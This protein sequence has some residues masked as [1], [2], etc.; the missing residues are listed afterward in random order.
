[1]IRSTF[2]ASKLDASR[3]DS[4]GTACCM[5]SCGWCVTFGHN[6]PIHGLSYQVS[7]LPA[8]CC[9]VWKLKKKKALGFPE[10]TKQKSLGRE[11]IMEFMRTATWGSCPS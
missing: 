3:F 8:K 6:M 1:M 2:H 11:I 4:P 7:C 5:V 10:R 9:F